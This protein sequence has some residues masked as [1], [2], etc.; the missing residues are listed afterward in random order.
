MPTEGVAVE[1]TWSMAGTAPHQAGEPERR[2][3]SPDTAGGADPGR[4]PAA[5]G[6]TR[7]AEPD[8]DA[9]MRYT[10]DEL[11]AISGVPSRTIRFY[12]S[13]GTL[14]G[15]E[16]RGRVAYYRT[17]HVDRLRVIADLQD[18][19]LRLDAIREVLGRLQ[20]GHDSLH[21]WLGVGDAL[22]APW[23][24]EKPA[25]LTTAELEARFNSSRPGSISRLE[26][27]GMVQR[28]GNTR[29]ASYLVPSPALLEIG[30]RLEAAG[31]DL[32]VAIGAADIMRRRLHRAAEELVP[33]FAEHAGRGFG[34]D[35]DP[36]AVAT[37]YQELRP[38]GMQ[39]VQV[40]FAQEMERA[41]RHFVESGQVL[42]AARGSRS[43]GRR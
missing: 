9:P 40:I 35:G 37:A 42:A 28:Q 16:K 34:R 23:L 6:I 14:P 8:A 17:E 15:P 13:N 4:A 27:A 38:L 18:R 32:E 43:R 41:L 7:D 1:Q 29:P 30:I 22:Q 36:E 12:Q 21:G 39:A 3:D 26:R 33:F 19:G 5:E 20:S 2:A 24:D 11:A 10:I 25:V 31:V